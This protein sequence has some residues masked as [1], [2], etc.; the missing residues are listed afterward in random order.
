VAFLGVLSSQVGLQAQGQGKGKGGG[1]QAPQTPRATA[2][3]DLTGY[4]VSVVTE[5]WRYRMV[6]PT[7]G[8]YQGIGMTPEARQLADA[9][10]PANPT[11]AACAAYGAPALLRIPGRL[12]ITWEDDSTLKLETDAGKQIRYFHFGDW[13]AP[14]GAATL[15]GNTTAEWGRSGGRGGGASN[16]WMNASTTNLTAGLL[17]KNGIP[18]SNEEKLT[19]HFDLIKLPNGDPLLVVTVITDDPKY[20]RQPLIITSHFRKEASE[21]KWNPSDCSST[22]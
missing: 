2:S 20:L 18:Y 10:D 22:W 1:K 16:G 11:G 21:A 17:R 12:H 9:F 19:E 8:G 14:P 15:Q 13:K 3:I 5:D 7:K 6:M 4:W